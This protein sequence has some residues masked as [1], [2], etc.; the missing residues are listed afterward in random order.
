MLLVLEIIFTIAAWRRGWGA[1]ALIPLGVARGIAFVLGV[2]I[3]AA[4]GSVQ[5][6]QVAALFG[7]VIAVIALGAMAAR[8]PDSAVELPVAK[9]AGT[10][11]TTSSSDSERYAA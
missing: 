5:T 9:V 10:A 11:R 3:V 2:I 8:S 6:A 7:D 4:G 1:R